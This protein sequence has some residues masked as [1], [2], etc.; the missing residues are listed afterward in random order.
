[1]QRHQHRGEG[2]GRSEFPGQSFTGDYHGGADDDLDELMQFMDD[3]IGS[4]N[5]SMRGGSDLT[6]RNEKFS[7]LLRQTENNLERVSRAADEHQRRSGLRGGA[8]A[9]S[10]LKLYNELSAKIRTLYAKGPGKRAAKGEETLSPAMAKKIAGLVLTDV[11]KTMN[12]TKDDP[13]TDAMKQKVYDMAMQR[14]DHYKRVGKDEMAKAKKLKMER[15]KRKADR[16]RLAEEK[17][18][19]KAERAR[20]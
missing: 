11:R 6:S 19:R 7:R 5:S 16:M 18:R 1:M 13:V 2:L 20:K 10:A 8:P 9:N 4:G 17:E 15:E 3:R 12:K 14:I